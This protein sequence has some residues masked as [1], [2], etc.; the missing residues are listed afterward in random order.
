MAKLRFRLRVT[1]KLT[2]AFALVA[3]IS[4]LSVGV[5]AFLSGR[6]ALRSAVATNVTSIAIEKTEALE[7]WRQERRLEITEAARI[8]GEFG[9]FEKP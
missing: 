8:L 1:P 4:V 7:T 3:A 9:V 2:L 5:F 6:N